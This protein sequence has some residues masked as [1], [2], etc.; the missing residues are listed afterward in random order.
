MR[1]FAFGV[2]RRPTAILFLLQVQERRPISASSVLV[3]KGQRAPQL[4]GKLSLL[5]YRIV[6]VHLLQALLIF[7]LI[8]VRLTLIFNLLLLGHYVDLIRRLF[9]LYSFLHRYAS[10]VRV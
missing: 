6:Q 8:Q 9:L 10:Y 4:P 5:L 1:V 3:L 7:H 2:V